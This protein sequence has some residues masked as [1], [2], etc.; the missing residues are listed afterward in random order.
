MRIIL[1]DHGKEHKEHVREVEYHEIILMNPR[2][3][4]IVDLTCNVDT[5][6]CVN[7]EFSIMNLRV[8]T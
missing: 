3:V 5:S 4:Q 8:A 7:Y 6:I 2:R 1:E